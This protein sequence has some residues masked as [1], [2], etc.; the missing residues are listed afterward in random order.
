[1]S[2]FVSVCLS[3]G[4]FGGAGHSL[5]CLSAWA[6]LVGLECAW[7]YYAK[8][9]VGKIDSLS[10]FWRIFV[11]Y[12]FDAGVLIGRANTQIC[13]AIIRHGTKKET[14]LFVWCFI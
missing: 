13:I 9:M 6:R 1:M 5:V 14:M 11:S 10:Q 12:L 3:M 4:A 8:I 7:G 2:L